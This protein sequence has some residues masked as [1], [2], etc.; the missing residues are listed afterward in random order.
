MMADPEDAS[1]QRLPAA[2]LP[3]ARTPGS[4][5][6]VPGGHPEPNSR[7][8]HVDQL[9][10]SIIR[11]KVQPP[12]VRSSTLERPRLLQWLNSHTKERLILVSGEA[13][14]GKTTLLSDFAR[15]S[16]ARCLWYRLDATDRDWVTFITYV[17]AAVR[18]ARPDFGTE[19]A[20]LLSQM[21]T[22]NLTL[23]AALTSLLSEL[24]GIGSVPTVLILD[25]FQSV[26]DSADIHTI[27]ARLFQQAPAN[28]SFLLAG[29]VAPTVRIGRLEAHGEVG[30]LSTEDLRFSPEETADL[31]AIGYQLPLEPDLVEEI[32]ARAEGWAASLQLVYSSIRARRPSEAR[33][34]I[35]SLSGTEGALYDYLAEEVLAGLAEPLQRLL[36]RASLLERVVPGYVAAALSSGRGAPSIAEVSS[37]LDEADRLGLMG[38]RAV[39][40]STWRFHPLL[41]EYLRRQL[42]T[43]TAANERRDMHRRVARAAEQTNDWLAA[44]HHFIEGEE[45]AEA[46]RVLNNS[47]AAALGS[48][49]LGASMALVGRIGATETPAAVKVIQARHLISIGEVDRAAKVL[50]ELDGL[51]SAPQDRALLAIAQVHAAFKTGRVDLMEHHVE[52]VLRDPELPENLR[53]IARAWRLMMAAC[54]GGDIRAAARFLS[55]LG[56]RQAQA[57]QHFFAAISLHNA[58]MYDLAQGRFLAALGFADRALS[59]FGRATGDFAEG[60]STRAVIATACLELGYTE[61]AEEETRHLLSSKEADPDAYLDGAWNAAITG[62]HE[63][64]L[65]FRHKAEESS[66]LLTPNAGMRVLLDRCS[67]WPQSPRALPRQQTG[68]LTTR[69]GSPLSRTSSLG[70]GSPEHRSDKTR[71]RVQHCSRERSGLPTRKVRREWRV[72]SR[73][74]SPRSRMTDQ[75]W[76]LRSTE[77]RMLA[78]WDFQRW[79]TCC[80]GT[81]TLSRQITRR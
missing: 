49:A 48:G 9:A 50:E 79:R 16:V 57:G 19:T 59:E 36:V 45:P 20:A 46:M 24:P 38:R 68:S 80:A 52:A 55:E 37:L 30:R 64:A 33:A 28:L 76:W 29:R 39:G 35:Q 44:C 11:S 81:S 32:D 53:D 2:G 26:D 4:I 40:A 25:D 58:A 42:D 6:A 60:L 12:P 54:R 51:R 8:G 72:E 56:E 10:R 34:F 13:G 73:L 47:A 66:R 74:P 18:E 17:I 77:R 69:P 23:E 22:L 14:Y 7:S 41:R 78:A 75:G 27:L 5:P 15:R 67:A 21:A 31:F 70:T 1:V 65:E 3:P 61:R 62:D 63:R 43:G 71:P